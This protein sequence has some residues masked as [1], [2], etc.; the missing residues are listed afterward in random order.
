MG[1]CYKRKPKK[2]FIIHSEEESVNAFKG[3]LDSYGYNTYIP[4]PKA[5]FDLTNKWDF[6]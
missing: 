4:N 1:I 3:V 5:R 2:V 6:K